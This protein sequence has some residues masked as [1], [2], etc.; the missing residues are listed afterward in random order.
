MTEPDYDAALDADDDWSEATTLEAVDGHTI[1]VRLSVPAGEH[2]GAIQIVH[3]LG[4]H[5]GRYARFAR[6]AAAR[7]FVVIVHDHRGHGG[8]IEQANFFADRKGWERLI[9]DALTVHRYCRERFPSLPITM[10]GHSM[11]SF[12]AQ[13][14]AML[15]GDRL[16][17]LIVSASTWPNRVELLAGHLLARF[18]AWRVGPRR[19]SALLDKLGFGSHNKRFEPARTEHDWLSRDEAEVD[20]YVDD[21]LCGGPYTAGLWVDLTGGLLNISKDENVLRVPSDL[22]ILITGGADD[23][24]GGEQRLGDLALHYAQTHHA[25]LK[26][27]IY[28][29]GRHEMLNETNRDEVTADWL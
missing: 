9:D 15:H 27:K 20:A 5:S 25:R 14:F 18:E 8:H 7:G 12:V 16:A 22:P 13:N 24:V 3:G 28:P 29:E 6:A 23:P 19:E 1:H 11:G 21:P 26:V 4:E 10:L 17:G 2:R